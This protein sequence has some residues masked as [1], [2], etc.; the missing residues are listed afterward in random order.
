MHAICIVPLLTLALAGAVQAE[1]VVI[2][3]QP[4]RVTEKGVSKLLSDS[5]KKLGTRLF[6]FAYDLATGKACSVDRK[7][8]LCATNH[9]VKPGE[10]GAL[11]FTST[12]KDR[13]IDT[14]L[15][16]PTGR[17]NRISGDYVFAGGEKTCSPVTGLAIDLSKR[18]DPW[19]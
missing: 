2:S 1:T 16:T 12:L 13:R 18:P 11:T 9:E 14:T 4:D 3:C 10:G 19:S 6:I 5:E 17:F 8:Q 7:Y 15:V